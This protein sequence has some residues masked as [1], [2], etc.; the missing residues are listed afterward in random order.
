MLRMYDRLFTNFTIS[1]GFVLRSLY[2]TDMAGSRI[3]A[4]VL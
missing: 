2:D 4:T 3:V 1:H